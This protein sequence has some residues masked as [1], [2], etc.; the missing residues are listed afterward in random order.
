MNVHARVG[1]VACTQPSVLRKGDPP[2]DRETRTAA[3]SDPRE[4]G[5]VRGNAPRVLREVK[6]P[7][8]F[9]LINR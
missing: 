7:P 8:R 3:S 5:P 4:D 2:D 6:E 9:R 1:G